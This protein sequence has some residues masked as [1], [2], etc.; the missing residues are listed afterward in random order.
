MKI[1]LALLFSLL[2]GMAHATCPAVPADCLSTP[3][4]R[5]IAIGVAPGAAGTALFPTGGLLGGTW[6]GNP[7]FTGNWLF[8]GSL[9]ATPANLNITLSPSGTGRVIINPATAGTLDNMVIGGTTRLAGNFTTLNL[10]NQLTSTLATGTAPFVI[11]STTN[12][13]N[14]NA[15]SLS[16]ATFAAP[17]PIGSGTPSTGAFTTLAASST[18]SGAGVTSLFASPPPIGSTA[19]STGAFTTLTAN[20]DVTFTPASHN[21]VFSPT[22]IGTVAISPASNLTMTPGGTASLSPTGVL[23]L[24]GQTYTAAGAVSLGVATST[25]GAGTYYAG[26]GLINT[27]TFCASGCT[28]TGGTYTPTA[29]TNQVEIIVVAAGG[30]GGGCAATSGAQSCV[31]GSGAGGS[32]GRALFTSGFSGI[33]MTVGAVGTAGTSGPGSGGTG[34]TTSAGALI[35]CPGGGGGTLGSVSA[36]TTFS[37]LALGIA[38]PSAC[39]FSGQVTGTA[40]SVPGGT[41][42]AGFV[43]STGNGNQ[44]PGQSGGTPLGMGVGALYTSNAVT[45]TGKAGTGYGWGAGG[46]W[47]QASQSATA[48]LAGGPSIIIVKE[49]N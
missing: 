23:T 24:K 35:S 22:G 8:S 47:N 46:S 13:A 42:G 1:T 5:S 29:G 16:G 25:V 33:T 6:T 34:G 36:A 18:I 7:T 41:S 10:N 9:T 40:V 28:A 12:V 49:Y 2:A 38:G 32:Y 20:N 48:G 39:T 31:S 27:Q 14:L 21:L 30:G 15:S 11:A 45:A 19:A 44:F 4:Y 3:V 17:G 43:A 26:H 37:V